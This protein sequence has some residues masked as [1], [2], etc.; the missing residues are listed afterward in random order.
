[1][2][3]H[4]Q[5]YQ[6]FALDA[7]NNI[8]DIRNISDTYNQQYFCP[9]CHNE[10]IAKRGNIRQWHFAHKTTKCSYN[11]YLHS[12]A[13]KMIMD[14]FNKQ[15]YIVLEMDAYEKCGKYDSCIFH[16]DKYCVRKTSIQHNLKNYYSKCTQEQGYNGF[17]ADLLCEGKDNLTFPIFI[18]IFVTYQC[19]E[20]KKKSGI[21]II[22]F[23]IQSEED[24][25]Q[26]INSTQIT[27]GNTVQLYNFK[28]K[29]FNKYDFAHPFQKYMLYP[30]FKSFVDK[31]YTCKDYN[32]SHRGI[33][34]I[35][36]PYDEC[37]NNDRLYSIGKVKAYLDGYI[38]KDCQIC[39]WQSSDCTGNNICKLYKKCGNPKYCMDNEASKC[40]MFRENKEITQC[41]ISYF[42]DYIKTNHI[43]VW[44]GKIPD[45]K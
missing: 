24:I 15:E 44:K 36:M 38:K 4:Y 21:R 14:W 34:E 23:H 32:Q 35:S 3:Q 1:M 2:M 42:N 19:S 43:D 31:K 18:E 41:A 22:E 5:Q 27:E 26:I 9:H 12:I 30:S 40:P 29:I 39:K 45:T 13:E 37:F 17:I 28:R 20:E 10:M 7:K 11:N 33:Y 8:I 25:Q 16:T 6:H